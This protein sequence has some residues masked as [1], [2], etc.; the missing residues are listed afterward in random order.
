MAPP[1]TLYS[2]F[3]RPSLEREQAARPFL[4]EE[5]DQH[6]DRDLAEHGTGERL[7]EL[8]GDAEGEGADQRAPEV[9]NAAEH[10]HHERIDDVALPEI[11]AH[12]VDLRQRNARNSGDPGAEPE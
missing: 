11:G 7:E 8:V 9:S 5:D 12:I 3:H 10:H 1:S 6:Q 2:R 4:N